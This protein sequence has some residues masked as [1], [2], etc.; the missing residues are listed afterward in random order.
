MNH[1]LRDILET[2][3]FYRPDVGYIQGMSYLAGNLLLYMAPYPAFVCFAN[4]L[5][6]PYFHTFLKLNPTAM[7]QRYEVTPSPSFA[8]H[9]CPCASL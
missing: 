9:L 5:N 1:Q 4:L 7:N 8:R 6:S 2:Y 3:C